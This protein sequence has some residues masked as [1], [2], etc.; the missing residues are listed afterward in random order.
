MEQ[1]LCD[2]RTVGLQEH[3]AFYFCSEDLM[4][5]MVCRL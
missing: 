4:F 5:V 3:L 2:V 1:F